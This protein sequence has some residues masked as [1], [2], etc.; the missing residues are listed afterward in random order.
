[1]AN[2]GRKTAAILLLL[3]LLL[4]CR[5]EDAG[6]DAGADVVRPVKTFVVSGG[7]SDL[8][9]SF[10]G[11]IEASKRAEIGFRVP[12]TVADIL[13]N[14]GDGV[15]EGQVLARIDPTDYEIVLRDR[16]AT[17]DNAERNFERAS[18]LIGSGNIS[19]LD[20]DQM[21]ADFR[22]A[23]AAMA[24]AKQDLIYTTLK[25][26][27]SGRIAKRH[28]ERFEEVV[29]K[30]IVFSLQ[31][32]DSLDVKLDLPESL[33]RSIRM[34]QD[35]QPR[36]ARDRIR[37]WAE[38]E[39]IPGERF[40]LDI[41]EVATKADPKT[42]TFEVTLTMPNPERFVVLPGMTATV[43][44]DFS[45]SSVVREVQFVPATAVVADS[46]L[47]ARVWVLDPQTMTVSSRPVQVAT[48]VGDQIQVTRGL[49]G[50]EEIVAVGA[51]YMAEGMQVTRLAETEQAE[52][53]PDDPL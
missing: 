33:V 43:T 35:E 27:F 30:Q 50:G 16:Q 3:M 51:S 6:Q 22:T 28:V 45:R 12:G 24:A 1:M 53:R 39:G 18:E 38:F 20:Y 13:V 36:D 4:A 34:E 21:E 14:E 25:A 26:P 10:P 5:G 19:R 49:A 44:A 37:A 15:A 42:Q 46:D 52:P 41:K 17:F 40:P 8:V 9:R 32:I 2:R 11:R 47:N 29:A 31:Q 23:S 48:M 7:E